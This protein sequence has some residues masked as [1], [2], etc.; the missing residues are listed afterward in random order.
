MD[1][2]PG[3]FEIHWGRDRANFHRSW[4]WQI[5]LILNT[6]FGNT[7]WVVVLWDAHVTPLPVKKYNDEKAFVFGNLFPVFQYV[8]EMLKYWPVQREPWKSW[9]WTMPRSFIQKMW[10]VIA[11]MP[12]MSVPGL[13]CYSYEK[14]IISGIFALCASIFN[15]DF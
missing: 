11:G 12:H 15:A 14:N 1:L 6:A 13:M 8:C 10:P 3:S 4:T 5:V 2:S 9:D 7:H